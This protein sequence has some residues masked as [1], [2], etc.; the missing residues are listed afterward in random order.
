[1]IGIISTTKSDY[2]V[3]NWINYCENHSLEFKIIDSINSD[4]I[5]QLKSCEHVLWHWN[6]IDYEH[7][8]VAKDFFHILDKYHKVKIFPDYRTVWHYDDK[9]AQTII[10]QINGIEMP[11]T[12]FT[13]KKIEALEWIENTTFPIV[14][15][16]RKGAGSN[17][18][19]LLKNKSDAKKIIDIMFTKGVK[20]TSLGF[21][22]NVKQLNF[23]KILKYGLKNGLRLYKNVNRFP[24]EHG[25]VYFQEFLPD[26]DRDYRIIVIGNKAYGFIR[27][28]RKNDFRASGSGNFLIDHDKIDI[29][30]VKTAFRAA[31]LLNMQSVAFDFLK[32]RNKF[33]ITEFSYDFVPSGGTYDSKWHGYWDHELNYHKESVNPVILMIENLLVKNY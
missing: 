2:F 26:C 17:N 8:F 18:V 10:L 9:I 5:E 15:K 21:K 1:M 23:K 16:L 32:H 30:C 14:F 31:K 11:K 22:S 4:T 27:F 12:W 28:T 6:L 33:Y 3:E 25:Y 29:E 24:K 7:Y 13:T 19:K 20:P